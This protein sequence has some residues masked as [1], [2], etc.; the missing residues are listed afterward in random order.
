MLHSLNYLVPNDQINPLDV[1]IGLKSLT[2]QIFTLMSL[3]TLSQYG[4][5]FEYLFFAMNF[6]NKE[7]KA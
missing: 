6:E 4:Y 1:T 5:I 2:V 7:K 3:K